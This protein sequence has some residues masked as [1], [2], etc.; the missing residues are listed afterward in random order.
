MEDKVY[1][2]QICKIISNSRV[3]NPEFTD[4]KFIDN[5]KD[6]KDREYIITDGKL[7]RDILTYREIVR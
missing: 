3:I 7:I 4:D 5:P 2:G 1:M 6:K